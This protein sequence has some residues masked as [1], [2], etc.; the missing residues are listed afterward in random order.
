MVNVT[1]QSQTGK[2]TWRGKLSEVT[3][4]PWEVRLVALRGA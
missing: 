1:D 3:L 2:L 4:K